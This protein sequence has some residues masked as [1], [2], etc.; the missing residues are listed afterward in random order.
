MWRCRDSRAIGAV[1]GLR[2]V[3]Q[4][5]LGEQMVDVRLDRWVD[6]ETGVLKR[7]RATSASDLLALGAWG[8]AA[9]ALA[10]WRFSRLP[11]TAAA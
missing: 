9:A 4:A 8:A 7:R 6:D 1:D 11:S 2:A 10:A 3:A 5:G